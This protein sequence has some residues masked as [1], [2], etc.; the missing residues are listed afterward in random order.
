MDVLCRLGHFLSPSQLLALCRSLVRPWM[1]GTSRTRH[2]NYTVILHKIESQDIYITNST[3][4]GKFLQ[5]IEQPHRLVTSLVI[6]C[7]Y[8]HGYYSSESP[9]CILSFASASW[10]HGTSFSHSLSPQLN[11]QEMIR[12]SNYLLFATIDFETVYLIFVNCIP[13]RDWHQDIVRS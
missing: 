10:R 13:L 11:L 2:Y 7:C 5:S 1:K 3:Y 12:I 8:F 6:V 9:S 4:F